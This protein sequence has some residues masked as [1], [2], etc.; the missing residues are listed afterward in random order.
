MTIVVVD[1]E[2]TG[3]GHMRGRDDA[4]VQVGFAWRNSSGKLQCF[5]YL[6][7]PGDDYLSRAD[8]KA[9]EVNGL[10]IER[11]RSFAPH[12]AVARRLKDH[13]E[14]VG[15]SRLH[16][17]NVAFD[18]PFLEKRPW[19]VSLPWG[20]CIMLAATPDCSDC[21]GSGKVFTGDVCGACRG[22][23]KGR[24][25]KLKDACESR[26]IDTSGPL[27]SAGHDARLAYLLMEK[28]E[29]S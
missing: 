3:F 7:N 17:Y 28:L 25:P 6:A 1:T 4:V 27:H 23:G 26:G 24:W 9:L 20:G 15:A 8:P 18:R 16:A 22:G 29:V 12:E 2:T 14:S 5:E 21:G 13:L 19:Q 10:T 11:V